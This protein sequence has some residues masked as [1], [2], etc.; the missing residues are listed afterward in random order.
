MSGDPSHRVPRWE[1]F[2]VDE[3]GFRNTVNGRR[4]PYDLVILGD[5]FGM[6]LGSS[7]EDTWTSILEREGHPLYNLSMPATCSAHGAARLAREL[8]TLPLS[9]NA[10]IVV[11]LY[12][13]NDLEECTEEVEQQLAEPPPSRATTARIAIDDYR[14]RSP[15]RQFGM[16]LVY[17][18]L[19]ADPVVTARSLSDGR[20]V[21]FYKPH[22][23]AAQLS[24]TEVEHSPNFSVLTRGLEKIRTLSEHH[25]AAMVVVILPTKEEVY[26]SILRGDSPDKVPYTISGFAMATQTFCAIHNIWCVDLTPPLMDEAKEQLKEGELLWWRDDS[27]WSPAGH[28]VVARLLDQALEGH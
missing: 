20:S 4:T 23:R 7:Q 24:A 28:R 9:P 10:T 2:E 6:G 8:P 17:R 22:I 11:P 5:S 19:F 16:R 18:W 15:L 21:L 25:H 3:R 27:H 14:V 13:G 26:R 12:V 1:L